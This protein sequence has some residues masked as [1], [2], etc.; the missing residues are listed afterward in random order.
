MAMHTELPYLSTVSLRHD[1][2]SQIMAAVELHHADCGLSVTIDTPEA[3]PGYLTTESYQNTAHSSMIH[4][5][6]I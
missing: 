5:V 6:K 1:Q 4:E 2:Q 3:P